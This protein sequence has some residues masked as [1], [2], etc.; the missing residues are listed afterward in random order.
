M[1]SLSNNHAQSMSP[2]KRFSASQYIMNL[3]TKKYQF[4]NAVLTIGTQ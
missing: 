1:K 4:S 2:F 3:K